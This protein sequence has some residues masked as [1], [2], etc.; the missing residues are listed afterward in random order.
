[1]RPISNFERGFR[2][3]AGVLSAGG[4][5]AGLLALRYFY[6]REEWLTMATLD[7]WI[8]Y[9]I[10]LTLWPWVAFYAVRWIARGFRSN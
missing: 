6:V 4:F 10:G 7:S 1:M 2:R 9:I 8:S 3:L 5:G